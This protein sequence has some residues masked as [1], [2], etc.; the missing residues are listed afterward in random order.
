MNPL[1]VRAH[2]DL[3]WM[4]IWLG[5]CPGQVPR[6]FHLGEAKKP[7]GQRSL[8]HSTVGDLRSGEFSGARQRPL[9]FVRA[10]ARRAPTD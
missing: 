1:S 7:E 8:C 6:R 2:S 5:P 3:E 10:T 4:A 9:P